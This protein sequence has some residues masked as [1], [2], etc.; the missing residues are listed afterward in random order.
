M[1]T[2]QSI[3][4]KTKQNFHFLL[5]I[6]IIPWNWLNIA[7]RRSKLSDNCPKPGAIFFDAFCDD[8]Y[9]FNNRR[10]ANVPRAPKFQYT[11]GEGFCQEKNEKNFKKI[12]SWK[13]A[14]A[15]L[16]AANV[17]RPPRWSL[18]NYQRHQKNHRYLTWN[19]K[20]GCLLNF[21]HALLY[22]FE[23]IFKIFRKKCL[24]S[25]LQCAIIITERERSKNKCCLQ[26]F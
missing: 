19:F 18:K 15:R 26:L 20:T 3:V 6:L 7:P 21:C 24:T 4:K 12:F 13:L 22:L 23:K 1:Q 8:C 11:T 17:S 2:F 16:D 14:V 25:R 10:G 9:F 5:I